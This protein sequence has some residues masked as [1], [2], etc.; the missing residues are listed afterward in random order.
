MSGHKHAH[1]RH[2][3]GRF[4]VR[5]HRHAHEQMPDHIHWEGPSIWLVLVALGSAAVVVAALT[6]FV[7]HNCAVFHVCSNIVR[8]APHTFSQ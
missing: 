2:S 4:V 6:I 5:R 3:K 8:D 1:P 7:Q